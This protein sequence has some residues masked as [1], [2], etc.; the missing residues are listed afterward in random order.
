MSRY[1]NHLPNLPL[2][3]GVGRKV[4]FFLGESVYK[5]TCA[6]LRW[7]TLWFQARFRMVFWGSG[8]FQNDVFLS[9]DVLWTN[10]Y[11]FPAF[12][13]S[14]SKMSRINRFGSLCSGRKIGAQ[15]EVFTEGNSGYHC[16]LKHPLNYPDT[17]GE[18][19]LGPLWSISGA[20][21]FHEV[22]MQWILVTLN[23]SLRCD[24]LR[25]NCLWNRPKRS[26]NFFSDGVRI[27]KWMP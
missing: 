25:W 1:G 20:F 26:V 5:E 2:H 15:R 17:V 23:W 4:T 9:I 14:K 10:I 18:N 12:W 24:D 7:V 8:V 3:S 16:A 13:S 27:A 22:D 11:R 6:S 21:S 19:F